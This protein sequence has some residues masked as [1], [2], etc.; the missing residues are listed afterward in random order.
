MRDC[1]ITGRIASPQ[2]VR[3]A[4]A[5]RGFLKAVAIA[6]LA[7]GVLAAAQDPPAARA[8]A[9]VADALAEAVRCEH[10][11]HLDADGLARVRKEIASSLD[12]AARLRRAAALHNADEPVTLF[13]ALPPVLG[14][15]RR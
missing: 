6:P 5:R 12:A 13:Q 7:P 14:G 15:G 2:E 9:G 8:E 1:R 11:A 4:A 3:V 10:G